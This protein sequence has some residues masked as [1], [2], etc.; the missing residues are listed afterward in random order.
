MLQSRE[1]GYTDRD[2]A[3]S[4]DATPITFE[5]IG[6]KKQRKNSWQAVNTLSIILWLRLVTKVYQ[7]LGRVNKSHGCMANEDRIHWNYVMCSE[8]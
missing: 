3:G 5:D 4:K 1:E 7:A 6:V 2:H 8:Y